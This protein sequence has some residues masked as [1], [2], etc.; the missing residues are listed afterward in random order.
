MTSTAAHHLRHIP[1]GLAFAF[2]LLVNPARADEGGVSFWAPGQFGSLAAVP[3]DPGWSLALSYFHASADAGLSKNFLVGGR[4][5]AGIDATADLVFAFPTYTFAQPV[6]GGQA[7]LSVG[8]AAGQARGSAGIGLAGP[9]GN[10]FDSSQSD[11]VTGGS[12]V[13]GLGTLKWHD[14]NDNFMVYG[15]FGIP[16]GAYRVGRLANLGTNH[17]A[18]DGGGGYTYFDEKKGREFSIVGGLTYNF[19]NTDTHY[20][21]GVD[22]HVDWAASQFLSEQVHVGLVGYFYD[23]LTG[24]SGS[25]ATLGPFK[26]RVAAVGP[27]VGY[28]FPIGAQKGYLNL[29]AYWEFAAENRA[30]G[31]NVWLT[32]ALPLSGAR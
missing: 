10:S 23:Q 21:N 22:A 26:S 8:W 1:L 24:D 13:Y 17:G 25:G 19:E 28:F 31:W 18:I 32:L 15:M 6:F 4:L 7:A 27:Q 5:T 16:V 30:K 29:K 14:G 11:K 12:D 9:R 20:Q 3:S 2:A